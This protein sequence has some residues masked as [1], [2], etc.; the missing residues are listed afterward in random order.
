VLV[1]VAVGP[2]QLAAL[3]RLALLEAGERDKPAIAWA[4]Q[5]FLNTAA[6]VATLGDALWPDT[7]DAA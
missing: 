2:L 7:E 3:E 1:P 5:R 6:H 4:V